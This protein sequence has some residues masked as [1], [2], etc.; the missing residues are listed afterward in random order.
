MDYLPGF[1]IETKVVDVTYDEHE[2]VVAQLCVGEEVFLRRDAYSSYDPNAISV[3]RASG[4]QIG[5]INKHITVDLAPKFDRNGDSVSAIITAIIG[6]YDRDSN[7]TVKIEFVVPEP[8]NPNP[9]KAV[10]REPYE[11]PF[12][13]A[14]MNDGDEVT[15][16]HD[17]L[18]NE[19]S[20]VEDI[21]NHTLE[22]T[23]EQ[24]KI[25]DS[26][27]RGDSALKIIAFAGTGKTTTLLR[28][29]EIRPHLRFLYVAF[30]KSVRL[31]AEQKFPSNVT[32]KTSHSLAYRKFGKPHKDR[33]IPNLRLNDVKSR[34]GLKTYE[35]TRIVS[36]TFQ[37][38]LHSIDSR[39][40]EKHISWR[41]F[42]L[43]KEGSEDPSFYLSM[44]AKLWTIMCDPN[45]DR[46]GML[47]DCYLKQYQ[48]SR[49]QLDFD[50]IL[51]DEAQDTNPVVSDIVL[52]QK[53]PKI[54]VGDPHQQ[55][56]AFRGAQD[57]M[58][59]IKS[60]QQSYLTY[61]F[62]FG[63][64]I[65]WIANKILRTFKEE[66]KNLKGIRQNN[67]LDEAQDYAI[68]A[69][70]NAAVFDEA[71][72]LCSSGKIAFLGGINGYQFNDIVDLYRLYSGSM[73][74]IS[75]PYIRS[76]QNYQALKAFAEEADDWELKSKCK[77]VEKYQDSIPDLVKRVKATAV[78]R[79]QAD[80][81]ITTAH[82]SKG[83]QF[84]RVRL[85]SDFPPFFQD[86]KLISK[87]EIDADEFN[88]IYVAVTRAKDFIEFDAA[89]EWKNFISYGQQPGFE[90][91]LEYFNLEDS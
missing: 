68:I 33:L 45:E 48:L 18:I 83:S 16:T 70:T 72:R 47:H 2:P 76:F 22:L 67:K 64:E 51:L 44:A 35:Q 56:Y 69:R 9:E 27:I 49:P 62:R 71:A 37:K 19:M 40:H 86:N 17:I 28:Y 14:P 1:K 24:E 65:A 52:N 21:M 46:I 23:D 3:E 82:K 43:Q 85:C 36:E 39:F 57:A 90:K 60:Q 25:I 29:T 30:N 4:E 38:F 10:V 74:N 8:R 20:S 12:R 42:A 58:R 73:F 78:E 7:L 5:Y 84:S 34:L 77:V 80:V 13:F 54:L 63:S 15:T 31:E 66:K 59:Q 91:I 50:C 75:N 53:C 87:T 41:R 88:L 26:D 79:A 61:S 32:C 81:I 89:Y 11:M 55:I 6:D